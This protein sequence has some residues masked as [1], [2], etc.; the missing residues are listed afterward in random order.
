MCFSDYK[1]ISYSDIWITCIICFVFIFPTVPI[2]LVVKINLTCKPYKLTRSLV[3]M[4]LWFIAKRCCTLRQSLYATAV[5]KLS[6]RH[7]EYSSFYA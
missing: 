5:M 6:A 3:V 2:T 7:S 1:C 4:K